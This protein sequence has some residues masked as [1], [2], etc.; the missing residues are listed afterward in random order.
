MLQFLN[1]QCD[2]NHYLTI[3]FIAQQL[4]MAQ[5]KTKEEGINPIDFINSID[6]EIRRNDAMQIMNLMGQITNHPPKM[7]GPSI[8]G[9]D[10]YDYVYESGHSGT[11][12]KIGF[13][14]RKGAHTLYLMLGLG[15]FESAL[16]KLGKHTTGKGCLYIKKLKD[17]D[18][19]TLKQIIGKSYKLICEK[20]G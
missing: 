18:V 7:W 19:E 6:D 2:T 13:S 3:I 4:R 5:I 10:K 17:I 11:M 1:S 20:Y 14:P 16:Q 8:I 12:C 15:D 9:F